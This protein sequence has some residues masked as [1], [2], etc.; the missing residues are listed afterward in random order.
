MEF[1]SVD[2]RFKAKVAWRGGDPL[3]HHQLPSV[4][5]RFGLLTFVR[6]A[7]WELVFIL[8][9]L[10]ILLP[11]ASEVLALPSFVVEIFELL[12]PAAGLFI[13]RRLNL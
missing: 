13:Q 10:R 11:T 6:V 8:G 3:F 1:I 9:G 2:P 4:C 5:L 12:P 7:E